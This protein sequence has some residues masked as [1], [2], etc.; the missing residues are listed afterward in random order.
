MT[1]LLL[2]D[3]RLAAAQIMRVSIAAGP[4]LAQIFVA[5]EARSG[6]FEDVGFANGATR[7]SKPKVNPSFRV[8]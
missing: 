6:G 3:N 7:R 1:V 5:L 8:W 4:G 2:N